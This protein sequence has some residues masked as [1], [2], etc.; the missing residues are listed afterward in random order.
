MGKTLIAYYS[1]RG[2]NY[3]S[4]SIKNLAKGNTEIVAETIH[5]L[6]GGDLYQIESVKKYPTDY[7]ECT[8]VA[9][10]E[11]NNDDRPALFNPLPSLSDYDTI[12]LCYPCWWGT[13]PRVVATFLESYDFSGKIIKPLQTHEG[14]G[15]GYSVD[16]LKR[17]LPSSVIKEGL[18]IWGNRANKSKN[19]IEKWIEE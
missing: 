6:T 18:A 10:E 14:S 7:M 13:F 15:L 1:R 16:E 5:S 12:Y 3:V 8:R 17:L 11:L 4:G 9:K 2:E 19:D